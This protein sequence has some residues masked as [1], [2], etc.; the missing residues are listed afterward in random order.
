MLE[1]MAAGR[2]LVVNDA[3]GGMTDIVVPDETGLIVPSGAV[4]ALAEAL[5]R[6]VADPAQRR[7]LGQ[8]GRS[9]CEQRFSARGM[10]EQNAAL[11][12]EL[13]GRR[14]AGARTVSSRE[15]PRQAGDG[16]R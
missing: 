12:D 5:A 15:G 8:N 6:L 1:A 3:P 16:R 10:V 13:L 9:R 14:R 7:H 4:S 11:Y 2:P